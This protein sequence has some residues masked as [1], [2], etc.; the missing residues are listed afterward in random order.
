[1]ASSKRPQCFHL[2]HAHPKAKNGPT[3]NPLLL[4]RPN[5]RRARLCDQQVRLL[6]IYRK[7]IK[8]DLSAA[9]K[10]FFARS[11]R[12]GKSDRG[13]TRQFGQK[14][15]FSPHD[16]FRRQPQRVGDK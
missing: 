5:P 8:D 3:R 1:V 9:E 10:R 4:L 6:L 13:A 16:S 2:F 12:I 7:G 15:P 14:L 11:I